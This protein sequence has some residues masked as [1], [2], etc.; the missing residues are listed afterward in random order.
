MLPLSALASQSSASALQWIGQNPAIWNWSLEE[1]GQYQ[2]DIF[3]QAGS[4]WSFSVGWFSKRAFGERTRKVFEHEISFPFVQR[5]PLLPQPLLLLNRECWW[6][7][8][9]DTDIKYLTFAMRREC[10]LCPLLTRLDLFLLLHL[11]ANIN[12]P[13][14]CFHKGRGAMNPSFSSLL[15]NFSLLFCTLIFKPWLAIDEKTGLNT[16]T[17]QQ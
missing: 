10:Y 5:C 1:E 4:W 8:G 13:C 15:L 16:V 11:F 12:I 6:G 7:R 2:F 14:W 9:F 17:Q 3:R